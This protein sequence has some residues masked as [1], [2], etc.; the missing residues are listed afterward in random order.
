MALT[1]VKVLNCGLLLLLLYTQVHADA[2]VKTDLQRATKT[3]TWGVYVSCQQMQAV[4]GH[5]PVLC[6]CHA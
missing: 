2:V 4:L 6:S 1:H 3:R 5:V